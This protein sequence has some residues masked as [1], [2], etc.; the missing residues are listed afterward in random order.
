MPMQGESGP[1]PYP[2]IAHLP[3]VGVPV[4][5]DLVLSDKEAACLLAGEVVAEEKL[6]GAN[7]AVWLNGAGIPQAAT[8]GGPGALDR[9]NQL[10]PLRGWVA[11][12]GDELRALLAPGDVLYGE[13]LWWRHAAAYDALPDWLVGIDLADSAGGF[14]GVD[15]RN[16]RLAGVSVPAPPPLGHGR[17]RGRSELEKC[18]RRSRFG[19]DPAEGLIVRSLAGRRVAKVVREEFVA[20][21]DEDWR[22]PERNRLAATAMV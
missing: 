1:P 14:A 20:R 5:D 8:R 3:P 4:R 19:P 18:L 12:H 11:A 21:S 6:D 13:W 17:F 15:E 2:R 9:G 16:R 10:G 7:V 22:R